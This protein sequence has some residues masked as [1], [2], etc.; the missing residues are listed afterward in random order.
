[1]NPSPNPSP[2]PPS[3]PKTNPMMPTRLFEIE[4]RN[5]PD[6]RLWRFFTGKPPEQR[7][8]NWGY[9]RSERERADVLEKLPWKFPNL[10]FRALDQGEGN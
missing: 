6:Q 7:W 9:Y 2:F 3:D 4:F 8:Q 1:M 5:K 10:E